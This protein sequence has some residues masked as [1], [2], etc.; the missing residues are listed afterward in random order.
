[1]I[2]VYKFKMPIN[3]SKCRFECIDSITKQPSVCTLSEYRTLTSTKDYQTGTKRHPDCP[4]K[5]DSECLSAEKQDDGTC[6]GFTNN[7]YEDEIH[8][9]C[10]ECE[11]HFLYPQET[12]DETTDN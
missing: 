4:L 8:F 10:K 5:I 9:R 7:M 2:A 3:C 11:I 6:L 1:M 12:A